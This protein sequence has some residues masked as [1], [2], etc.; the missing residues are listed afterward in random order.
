M[1][2][3]AVRTLTLNVFRGAFASLLARDHE[4]R[5]TGASLA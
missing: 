4:R 2:R 5:G 1:I 3:V